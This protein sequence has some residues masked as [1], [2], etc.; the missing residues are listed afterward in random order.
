MLVFDEIKDYMGFSSEDSA[1]LIEAAPCVLPHVESIVD[2]FYRGLNDNPRTQAVFEGPDQVERLRVS[3]RRWIEELFVGE[4][5]DAYFQR[6]MRIGRAH[7]AVGL[8]PH[9]MFGAM[10]IIRSSIEEIL[11]HCED[12]D[13][14]G[15]EHMRAMHRLLDIELTIMLQS[16]WDNMM[17]LKLK[18]PAALASGLAHE[19]R[20]P[21]NALALN[22]TLLERKLRHVELGESGGAAIMDAMRSE[23]RRITNLTTEIMDFAK[24]IEVE[25]RWVD[26]ASIVDAMRITLGP[27][28]E[29][30]NI[31]LVTSVEGLDL[32]WVDLDRI[33]QTLM[34]LL[35]NAIEASPPESE[36]HLRISTSRKG[37]DIVVRDEG[38]GMPPGM[39]YRIFD[40]FYTSKTTGT[41][42]GLP[43]V[44]K[45]V[46]AHEGTIDVNS[47][48]GRGTE[49]T[50]SLPRPVRAEEK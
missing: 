21:L 33:K 19:I 23:I 31:H 4:Y 32:V 15:F 20:N 3:L 39:Q 6:R 24:P 42:L 34:N 16:Y 43:I 30:S 17:E 5:D 29:A 41:G 1:L 25:P 2:A 13:G 7:V 12:L 36:V 38:A 46:E 35:T 49:F 47:K 48:P 28:M 10:N 26:A 8:L 18:V 40:L 45:I 22:V 44:K 14:R 11:W 50:L 37:T 9:F 27:T